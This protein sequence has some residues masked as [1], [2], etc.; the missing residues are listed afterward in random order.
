MRTTGAPAIHRAASSPPPEC[1]GWPRAS[2]PTGS[3]ASAT[4][5]RPTR[6]WWPDQRGRRPGPTYREAMADESALYTARVDNVG[7]TSGQVRLPGEPDAVLPT[8]A[9]AAGAA[10][11]SPE[12]VQAMAVSTC[13][14]QTLRAVLAE[15]GLDHPSHVSVEVRLHRD[16]AG[17]FRFAPRA[18]VTIDGLPAAQARPLMEAAHRRC[19]VSKLLTGQGAPPVELMGAEPRT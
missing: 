3:S 5:G 14:G 16:P 12:Q 1:T 13:L 7:G 11:Y 4:P 17:G 18:L 9:P 8:A 2:G 19:P 6:I 10:C 15:Q